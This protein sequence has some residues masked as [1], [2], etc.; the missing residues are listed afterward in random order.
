MWVC[1]LRVGK[2]VQKSYYVSLFLNMST[3][4]WISVSAWTF[5]VARVF[6]Y[7]LTTKICVY[8]LCMH[9]GVWIPIHLLVVYW[10]ANP[11]A[12]FDGPHPLS[13]IWNPF[14]SLLDKITSLDQGA[15]MLTETLAK[16]LC[17]WVPDGGITEGWSRRP[18]H[19]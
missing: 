7:I 16:A 17:K 14:K 8:K 9:K 5:K 15:M 12:S 2:L 1:V 3:H 11:T 6:T 18:G 19:F 10:G 4:T 13:I